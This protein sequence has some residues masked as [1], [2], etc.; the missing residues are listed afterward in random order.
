MVSPDEG[1]A[2]RSVMLANDL[3]LEFAMIHNRHKKSLK[4]LSPAVISRRTSRE[5]EDCSAEMIHLE[6]DLPEELA[7]G[8]AENQVMLTQAK[9][10]RSD[11]EKAREFYRDPRR[12]GEAGD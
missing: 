5:E 10:F 1:G 9:K 8:W 7:R 4:Q 11:V 12:H 2:K 3:G 6:E